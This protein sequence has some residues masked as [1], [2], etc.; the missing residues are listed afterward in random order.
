MPHAARS[1]VA[2][3]LGIGLLEGGVMA[4]LIYSLRDVWGWGFSNDAEV[5]HHVASVAPCL[6]VLALIYAVQAI[7]SGTLVD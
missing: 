4:S 6:A 2:V 7:L 3:S 5:V 1:A